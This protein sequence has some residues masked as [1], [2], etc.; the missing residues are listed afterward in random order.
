MDSRAYA[1]IGKVI[2]PIMAPFAL[3]VIYYFSG[4]FVLTKLVEEKENGIR[5]SLK[6]MSLG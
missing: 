4:G 5:E 6:I 3:I 1:M 2:L